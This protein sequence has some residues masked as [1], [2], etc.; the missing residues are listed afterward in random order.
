MNLP[1]VVLLAGSGPTDRNGNQPPA[2][3]TDLLKQVADALASQG[4][5]S[6]RYDN[7]HV[8]QSSRHAQGREGH[9]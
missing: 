3:M 7:A 5:A 9:G 1:G 4:I 2:L 6:L 8:R